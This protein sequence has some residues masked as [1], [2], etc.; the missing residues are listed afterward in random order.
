M[1][2]TLWLLYASKRVS[3]SHERTDRAFVRC[4]QQEL[5]SLLCQQ[6]WSSSTD[7]LFSSPSA[8]I[9]GHLYC[10]LSLLS[11]R[12]AK[13]CCVQ[14]WRASTTL[15]R[16]VL[17]AESLPVSF[18]DPTKHLCD[19]LDQPMNANEPCLEKLMVQGRVVSSPYCWDHHL[20]R[21]TRGIEVDKS[22]Y[23]ASMRARSHPF[24]YPRNG[25]CICF[26]LSK[27][28]PITQEL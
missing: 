4:I 8:V 11:L 28:L 14:I 25:I 12:T 24:Q 7:R 17:A 22:S 23:I 15:C 9:R 1:T 3:V 18:C 5:L 27:H 19:L 6:T 20:W 21:I 10:C 13:R 2:T 16:S 26:A